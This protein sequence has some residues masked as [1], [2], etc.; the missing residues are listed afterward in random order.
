LRLDTKLSDG[1][2]TYDLQK[3][4]IEHILPQRPSPD[5]NWAKLFPSKEI[6]EKYIHRLSNLVLLSR[7]KNIAAENFDFDLKK[8]KYFFMNGQSTP[9]VVTNQLLHYS[10]WT[11]ATI[12]QRQSQLLEKLKQLW[13]L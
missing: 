9:F 2:A 12:E 11:P 3:L 5:S 8:Q 1:S 6:Q 10:E 13:R 4:S 7:G